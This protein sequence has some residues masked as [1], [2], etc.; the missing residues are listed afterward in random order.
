MKV[1]TQLFAILAMMT[2]ISSMIGGVGLFY[3]QQTGNSLHHI[4][5]VTTPIVANSEELIVQMWESAAMA[6]AVRGETDL[7][8]IARLEARLIE[9]ETGFQQTQ[10][11]LDQLIDEP[12]IQQ[13]FHDA[14]TER[15]SF[16]QHTHEL[17]ES[18][19]IELQA[20]ADAKKALHAMSKTT[21][22]LRSN[23]KKIV[24]AHSQ[25]IQ[26]THVKIQ[27]AETEV[28]GLETSTIVE[29]NQ[30]FSVELPLLN[31]SNNLAIVVADM[32][33]KAQEFLS[34]ENVEMLLKHEK[35]FEALYEQGQKNLEFLQSQ[36]TVPEEVQVMGLIKNE[37][38]QFFD[39]GI[40]VYQTHRKELNA[41]AKTKSAAH[42]LEQE[43][44]QLSKGLHHLEQLA[45]LS[46]QQTD[47][48]ATQQANT[49]FFVILSILLFGLI[50][51]SLFVSALIRYILKVLHEV[52]V[53]SE[54]IA[55]GDLEVN[56]TMRH[57][58]EF[59]SL[60]H[61]FQ[62]MVAS[63]KHKTA[64]AEKVA[65]SNLTSEIHLSSD[66]DTL[67][68]ALQ[69][70]TCELSKV[71]NR[72]TEIGNDVTQGSEEISQAGQTLATGASEQAAALEEI[73]ASME[74]LST[75]T[76]KNAKNATH[77]NQL[78]L[79]AKEHAERG[80][81]EMHRMVEA[82]REIQSSSEDISKII[83]TIDEIAF[84]TNLLAIN[85]AVEAA[86]AG[87]HGKGFAVVADEVRNLAQRSS[88]AARETTDMI[89][90]AIKKVND[91]MNTSLQTS[92]ALNEIV[93]GSS[94]VTNLVE[95]IAF[96]CQEQSLGFK[97]INVGVGQLNTVLQSNA[98][99]AEETSASSERLF[100]HATVLKESISQFI[101]QPQ[102][103]TNEAL[104][105][106]ESS[107]TAPLLMS[108]PQT[109][110]HSSHRDWETLPRTVTTPS[111]LIPLDDHEFGRF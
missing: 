5:Q 16:V 11:K 76:D 111:S 66:R 27:L 65:E 28:Y 34:D 106:A 84:Q 6:E 72:V 95:E 23:L 69:K 80:N 24:T 40:V 99:V 31:A 25:K 68:K 79:T 104:Q 51:G 2:L 49:A 55:R 75:Q 21:S 39:L 46:S 1:R 48:H 90:G 105:S 70:M 61:S 29:I 56:L 37:F 7:A 33:E 36:I 18:H 57:N 88:D 103:G 30:L 92:T 45:E 17:I 100:T 86:R 54:T 101:L 60:I 74:E 82:M 42:A 96:A 110:T 4:T 85:A 15:Q 109:E 47:Q 41:K 107:A 9:V 12:E 89:E 94:Q 93:E 78:S 58:D 50:V 13:A 108:Q 83:K 52:R 38:K 59:G 14:L 97:E 20:Y 73:A 43:A 67:G 102:S 77:A 71:L 62:E 3:L 26:Q 98:Q 81:Q 19:R 63:L 22:Q 91:G 10:Q 44:L 87:I 64:I 8:E 35:E 32:R 53:G